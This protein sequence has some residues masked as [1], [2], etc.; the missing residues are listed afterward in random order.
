MKEDEMCGAWEGEM[1][2]LLNSSGTFP[3]FFLITNLNIARFM[4]I[5]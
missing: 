2:A 3:S 4:G 5:G 1:N